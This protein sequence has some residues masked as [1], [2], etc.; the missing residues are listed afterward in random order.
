MKVII[1]AGGFGTRIS[2]ESILKPKPLIEISGTPIIV[3]IMKWY[4][5]Y[6]FND[7]V[8]CCGYKGNMLKEY[9][10]NYL[11]YRNDLLLD[12]EKNKKFFLSNQNENNWKISLID[13]GLHTQTA[14][15]ILRLK[16]ILLN[17]TFMLTYGDGLSDIDINKLLEFHNKSK[18]ICTISLVSP[19]GRF[20]TV[21]V[22][23]KG[24][25]LEFIEKPKNER[26]WINGGFMVIDGKRIFDWI[27]SDKDESF[28]FVT[29]KKLAENN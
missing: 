5:K 3:D 10:A 17:E 12:F 16:D 24:L 15:R 26:S 1:L 28:E 13:T 19:I 7:F 11:I 4:S 18:K 22:D 6:K 25:I 29:L 14:S 27:N 9:F 23:K 2:E 8:I 21:N 20:G